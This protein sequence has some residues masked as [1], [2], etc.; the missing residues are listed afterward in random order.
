MK[1]LGSGLG[2]SEVS[3][4]IQKKWKTESQALKAQ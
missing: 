4:R 2:T 3:H 1:I